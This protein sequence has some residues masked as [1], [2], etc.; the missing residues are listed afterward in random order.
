M[1]K[2]FISFILVGLTLLSGCFFDSTDSHLVSCP[3]YNRDQFGDWVDADGDCQ[4]TRAEVLLRQSITAVTYTDSHH[5][6]V[7]SG[8][9]VDPYLGDTVYKA[10]E[11]DIDHVVPLA[12]CFRSGAWAWS[13][14]LKKEYANSLEPGHLLAVSASANRS[15]GDK[16]PAA[17]LP[18]NSAFI[19]TYA[20]LW[21]SVK[22]HWHLSMQKEE[23]A[24]LENILAGDS[25]S[26]LDLH[27]LQLEEQ[28]QCQ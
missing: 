26:L 10:S 1:N 22:L 18:K 21:I 9:W 14:S 12:E 23:E 11:L 8:L 25:I 27:S 17:W 20:K 6:T 28:P 4:N 3:T 5:C 2:K 15:K 7:D 24:R 16:D 13:D 19:Q